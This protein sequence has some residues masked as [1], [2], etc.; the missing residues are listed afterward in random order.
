MFLEGQESH[1]AG[2]EGRRKKSL[3]RDTKDRLRVTEPVR[4]KT[5]FNNSACSQKER[6]AAYNETFL[7][8]F[9]FV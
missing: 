7:F 8:L 2:M 1:V 6:S 3:V 5:G 9:Y 4:N